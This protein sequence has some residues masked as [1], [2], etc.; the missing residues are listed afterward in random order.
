MRWGAVTRPPLTGP[1]RRQEDGRRACRTGQ[2][3]RGRHR[4]S[5]RARRVHERRAG[6]AS[7]HAAQG[8]DQSAGAAPRRH[9]RRGCPLTETY[10]R[11]VGRVSLREAARLGVSRVAFAPLIRDQGNKKLGT[12]EVETA[13]VRG[14]LLAYDTEER[15]QKQGLSK[16]L[17]S[18]NGTSRQARLISM[19]R[20][21]ESRR[22]LNKQEKSSRRAAPSPTQ[23]GASP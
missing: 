23:R 8:L 16:E 12:G 15:L 7:H 6:D 20:L 9:R 18:T 14:M 13:V 3:A 21:R 19:R 11:G 17:L 5:A 1:G 22:R 10:G 4:L 2:A